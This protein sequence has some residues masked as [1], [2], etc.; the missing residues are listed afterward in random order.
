MTSTADPSALDERLSLRLLR[1]ARV[2]RVVFTSRAL[3]AV[4]PVPFHLDANDRVRF[5][6]VARPELLRAWDGAVVAF[7]AD[8]VNDVDGSGW[9]VTVVGRA[10]VSG[11]I[12]G[13]PDL[14]GRGDGDPA[15]QL[16]GRLLV[17][18]EP[19]L[20]TGRALQA[21]GPGE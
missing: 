8:Q 13:P 5:E 12:P 15:A 11:D 6:A 16:P 21:G 20:V 2:G 10:T 19:Q 3:P 4:L 17:S 1:Q 9:S 14:V 18:I 7:Q